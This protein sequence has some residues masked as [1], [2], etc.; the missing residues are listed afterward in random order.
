MRRAREELADI[1]IYLIRLS[2]VLGVDI[3]DAAWAKMA[4]NEKKY[5]IGISR[6]T[7]TKYNRR[8]P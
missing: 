6:G 1:F 3:V 5:P 7:A 2:D 4:T 8:L